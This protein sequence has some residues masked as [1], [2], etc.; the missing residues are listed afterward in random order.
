MGIVHSESTHQK[1]RHEELKEL[2]FQGQEKE[3]DGMIKSIIYMRILIGISF[4]LYSFLLA[5]SFGGRGIGVEEEGRLACNR[6]GTKTRTWKWRKEEDQNARVFSLTQWR[7]GV[8]IFYLSAK[9]FFW[10]IEY[11]R[12]LTRLLWGKLD[13][14]ILFVPWGNLNLFGP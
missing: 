4:S 2:Q 6:E 3:W 8:W 11:S 7:R 14:V 1:K 9:F 13:L 10:G 5:R 12:R